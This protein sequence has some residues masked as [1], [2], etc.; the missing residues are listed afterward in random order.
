MEQADR[1]PPRQFFLDPAALWWWSCRAHRRRVPLVPSALK[2]LNFLL[3]K[4]LLPFEAEIE[5]DLDLKH[6]GLCVI[7]HPQTTIGKRC[8]VHQ[9][10]TFAAENVIGG[11]HR[12]VVGDD[13]TIGANVVLL[14][15]FGQSLHIGDH[16]V[17]SPGSI[18][19]K[20]VPAGGVMMA[21]PA[22]LI[23]SGT[24]TTAG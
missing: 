19:S 4:C 6:H 20:D 12:I 5:A 8:H 7:V 16:A 3:Y 22:R 13:V 18:V 9:C 11:P 14:G 17:I 23:R 24:A 21:P 2:L 10:V 1:R 15:T